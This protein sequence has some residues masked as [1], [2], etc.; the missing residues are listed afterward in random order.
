MS[1]VVKVELEAP[2]EGETPALGLFVFSPLPR[3]GEKVVV[4]SNGRLRTYLVE[5]ITHFP[6]GSPEGS[7]QSAVSIHVTDYLENSSAG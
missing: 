7:E 3:G 2:E 5:Q 4:N 1:I 6:V